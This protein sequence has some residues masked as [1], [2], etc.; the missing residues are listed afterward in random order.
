MIDSPLKI[1]SLTVDLHEHL[2]QMPAPSAG[3]HTDNPPLSDLGSK[4]RTEPMPPISHRFMTDIN[5]MLM[6]QIFHRAER[7]LKPHV[8]HR[9]QANDFWAGFEIAK[10]IRLGHPARLRNH[11]A[12]LKPVS[13][14]RTGP[15]LPRKI[16]ESDLKTR[17]Q[18]KTAPPKA[19]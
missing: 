7:Q 12:R 11:P 16:W 6:Q 17:A 10:W 18:R 19:L 2:V 1:M 15:R 13:S 8:Q 5:A 3:F 14:D 9:C 4:Q